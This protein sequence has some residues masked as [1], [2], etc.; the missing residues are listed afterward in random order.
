MSRSRSNFITCRNSLP[1]EILLAT[2]EKK[3]EGETSQLQPNTANTPNK[4]KYPSNVLN[5][6]K[7]KFI[8]NK[9]EF[10]NK[11]NESGKV[12]KKNQ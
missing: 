4:N 5:F 1:K 2:T 7:P 3:S 10:L 11:T 9:K 12:N 8:G 6:K